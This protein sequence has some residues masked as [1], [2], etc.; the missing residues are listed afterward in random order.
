MSSSECFTGHASVNMHRPRTV[1]WWYC[2]SR[3]AR[4]WINQGSDEELKWELSMEG[5]G[6]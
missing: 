3:E 1:F 6:V 4:A 5:S 2:V